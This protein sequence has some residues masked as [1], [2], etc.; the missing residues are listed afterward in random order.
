MAE[1]RPHV[2][3]TERLLAVDDEP[4]I[5]RIVKLNLGDEGYT[6]FEAGT[7]AEAL[8][9]ARTRKPDLILLDVKLPDISG[10]EVLRRLREESPE[11]DCA[12]VFL[13]ASAQKEEVMLGEAAGAD[14]YIIKPFD[15][16]RLSSKVRAVL[17]KRRGRA[18]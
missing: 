16:S 11:L 4:V 10:V 12:V 5:R 15:I 13:T 14:D 2:R 8:E 7:G 1:R 6:V 9:V 3:A 17:D 18:A